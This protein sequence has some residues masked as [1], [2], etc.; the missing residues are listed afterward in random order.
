MHAAAFK[1]YLYRSLMK[2]YHSFDGTYG[3]LN[4][5]FESVFQFLAHLIALEDVDDA[6]VEQETLA[7]VISSRNSTRTEKKRKKKSFFRLLRKPCCICYVM[8]LNLSSPNICNYEHVKN[9]D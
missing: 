8:C 3:I 5:G 6:Q 7:F 2:F 1:L 4:D 9:I